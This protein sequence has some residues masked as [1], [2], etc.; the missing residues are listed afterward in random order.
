MYIC[1]L[2]RLEVRCHTTHNN[3]L[4][5]SIPGSANGYYHRKRDFFK[6]VL[7]KDG[8]RTCTK[9]R[10]LI[11]LSQFISSYPG[12]IM[13]GK[14][15]LACNYTPRLFSSSKSH[16]KKTNGGS[17]AT[18]IFYRQCQVFA[19]HILNMTFVS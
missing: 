8:A 16:V 7:T 12:F 11:P 14:T 10:V 2:Q 13:Y 15:F 19:L 18:V 3:N 9:S 17:A 5:V 6:G 4:V 1:L